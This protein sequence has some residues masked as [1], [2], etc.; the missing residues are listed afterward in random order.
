MKNANVAFRVMRLLL[1]ACLPL[2]SVCSLGS[3]FLLKNPDADITFMTPTVEPYRFSRRKER[4][5]PTKRD[6][7]VAYLCRGVF[8]LLERYRFSVTLKVEDTI[9]FMSPACNLGYCLCVL[10]SFLFLPRGTALALTMVTLPVGPVLVFCLLTLLAAAVFAFA[11]RPMAS[12]GVLWVCALAKTKLFRALASYLNLD[13]GED[14]DLLDILEVFANSRTG[15]FLKL[16]NLY[17]ALKAKAAKPVVTMI[18]TKITILDRKVQQLILAVKEL[19]LA[20]RKETV[21]FASRS[22]AWENS[23]WGGASSNNLID[24]P[25]S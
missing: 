9:G 7:Q 23:G 16:G 2:G 4:P 11:R 21:H 13:G 10:W 5:V 6:D 19:A 25:T 8:E 20:Q 24:D 3:L 18:S 17:S 22:T 14:V 15:Q 1:L 12:V